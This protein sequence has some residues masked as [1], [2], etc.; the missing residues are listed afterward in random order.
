LFCGTTGPNTKRQNAESHRSRRFSFPGHFS[1][2]FCHFRAF[3]P[4]S[5][6]VSVRRKNN[7][8]PER[9]PQV[10]PG[11]PQKKVS[12]S[13]TLRSTAAK[14]EQPVFA[15]GAIET[16]AESAGEFTACRDSNW[17]TAAVMDALIR[18]PRLPNDTRPACSPFQVP[19]QRVLHRYAS[20]PTDHSWFGDHK[21]FRQA[22]SL[23][24]GGLLWIVPK[25]DPRD[26]L[27][28]VWF[29][30]ICCIWSKHFDHPQLPI[31]S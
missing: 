29:D 16:T 3:T 26:A 7:C 31:L 9:D 25:D 17:C 24:F 27:R 21:Y 1:Q 18:L 11:T 30:V 15:G 6:Q 13:H 2:C 10:S 14:S 5:R 20:Q 22:S 4:T 23:N 12:N 8:A 19:A 28:N